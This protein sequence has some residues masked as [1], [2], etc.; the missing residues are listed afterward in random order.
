[1]LSVSIDVQMVG[2]DGVDDA[3]I[4][5]KSQE[6]VVELVSL[7]NQSA[8]RTFTQK[9][10]TVEVVSDATNEAGSI[11]FAL[12]QNMSNHSRGCSLAMRASHRDGE[13]TFRDFAQSFSRFRIGRLRC[14]RVSNSLRSYGTAGV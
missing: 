6:G 3:N 11:H 14:R 5:M 7:H 8:L 9:Q 1:M 4:G 10:V 13:V 12:M 2:I